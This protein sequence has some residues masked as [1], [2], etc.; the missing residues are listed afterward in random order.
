MEPSFI[1]YILS[2]SCETVADAA[3]IYSIFNIPY[4]CN[5]NKAVRLGANAAVKFAAKSEN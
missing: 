1:A 5:G 2:I 3:I 4:E